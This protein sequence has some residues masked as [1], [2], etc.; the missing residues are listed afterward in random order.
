[1]KK[2]FIVTA[3]ALAAVF[4]HAQTLSETAN[5]N[6]LASGFEWGNYLEGFL[7]GKDSRKA[8][9]G[10]PGL[11]ISYH[12][13]FRGNNLGFFVNNSILFP[14]IVSEQENGKS[15]NTKYDFLAQCNLILGPAYRF[16]LNERMAVSLGAGVDV[17]I[18]ESWKDKKIDAGS[19]GFNP[20]LGIVKGS[21]TINT[22]GL[23]VGG[24]LSFKFDFDDRWFF[25]TGSAVSFDFL[26]WNSSG[27]E[28]EITKHTA[29]VVK[30]KIKAVKDPY[31]LNIRPRIG[32]G[33][34]L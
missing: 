13:F 28:V 23:G 7:R 20:A 32:F 25:T 9:Y 26:K 15:K 30:N 3:L 34:N 14:L 27:I 2:M 4:A 16:T 24:D 31:S 17:F 8:Y 12:H 18:S 5:Q 11:V 21:E 29:N 10:S 1:M 19:S 22:L 6:W 33:V